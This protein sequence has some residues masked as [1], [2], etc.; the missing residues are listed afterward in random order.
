MNHSMKGNIGL[1]ISQGEKVLIENVRICNVE[2]KSTKDKRTMS[3]EAF[4]IA[5]VGS[6][7]VTISD[8]TVVKDIKTSFGEGHYIRYINM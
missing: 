7:N 6:K 3:T 4:G 8:D 5:I 1:F 2:N